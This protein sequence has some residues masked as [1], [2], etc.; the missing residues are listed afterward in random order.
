MTIFQNFQP[1]EKLQLNVNK[2]GSLACFRGSS[3]ALWR[4]PKDCSQGWHTGA[5]WGDSELKVQDILSRAKFLKLCNSSTI[6]HRVSMGASP[7]RSGIRY[8]LQ[9]E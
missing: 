9:T 2:G 6:L 5:E 7:Q 8:L 1:K 3:L 4:F